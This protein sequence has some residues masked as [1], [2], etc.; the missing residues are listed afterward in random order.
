MEFFDQMWNSPF[1]LL[2]IGSLSDDD[3]LRDRTTIP[4][5]GIVDVLDFCLLTTNF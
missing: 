2:L 1:K 5:D 4:V 3:T